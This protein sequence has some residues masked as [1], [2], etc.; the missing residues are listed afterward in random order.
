MNIS[1]NHKNYIRLFKSRFNL[2]PK[3]EATFYE[4]LKILETKNTDIVTSSV[5]NVLSQKLKNMDAVYNSL[6]KFRKAGL[7]KGNMLV[8]EVVYPKQIT[9]TVDYDSKPLSNSKQNS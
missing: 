6:T 2:T 9:I 8:K 7:L 4:L 1:V 3:Q 5:R